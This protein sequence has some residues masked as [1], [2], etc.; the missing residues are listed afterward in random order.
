MF[1]K[2][3]LSVLYQKFGVYLNILLYDLT[4]YPRSFPSLRGRGF[5]VFISPAFPMTV[6]FLLPPHLGPRKREGSEEEG[7]RRERSGPLKP[8]PA[9][10]CSMI[11]NS[12]SYL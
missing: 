2:R 12:L 8:T 5:C 9:T 1:E 11:K 10:C 4:T 6:I 3:Y 7:K